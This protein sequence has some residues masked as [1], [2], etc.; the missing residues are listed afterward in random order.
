V[1]HVGVLETADHVD[2]GV[3]FADVRQELVAEAF[4]LRRA[5]DQPGDVTNS[6]TVGLALGFTI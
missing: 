6:T 3:H 1:H 4:S 2:H 5:L